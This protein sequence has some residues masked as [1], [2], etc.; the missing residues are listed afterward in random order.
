M[1][2]EQVKARIEPEWDNIVCISPP[3]LV[4]FVLNT[5]LPFLQQFTNDSQADLQVEKRDR[6]QK[7]VWEVDTLGN[8]ALHLAI[9]HSKPAT[10]EYLIQLG[11]SLRES[12][13]ENLKVAREEV[14]QAKAKFDKF[15]SDGSESLDF[16]EFSKFVQ[17]LYL[18]PWRKAQDEALG[19]CASEE[20][21]RAKAS[22]V[23]E[24]HF[25]LSQRL[26]CSSFGAEKGLEAIAAPC[27]QASRPFYEFDK[28]K[29]E[30]WWFGAWWKEAL[31]REV[32]NEALTPLETATMSMDASR[33][34]VNGT[35]EAERYEMFKCVLAHST[36]VLWRFGCQ[37]CT[38]VKLSQIDTVR[39]N[40]FKDK[41]GCFVGNPDMDQRSVLQLVL[42]YDLERL[43]LDSVVATLMGL[44]WVSFGRSWY[45]FQFSTSF[46]ELLMIWIYAANNAPEFEPN[47]DGATKLEY[48]IML[49]ALNGLLFSIFDMM[50]LV[51]MRSRRE[52][53][54]SKCEKRT[55]EKLAKIWKEQNGDPDFM[56]PDNYRRATAVRH[57]SRVRLVSARLRT[58]SVVT[59]N[60]RLVSVPGRFLIILWFILTKI[61]GDS[62]KGGLVCLALGTLLVHC[63]ISK[64]TCY[65]FGTSRISTLIRK[66]M[67]KDI[68]AFAATVVIFILGFGATLFILGV[69][70]LDITDAWL[71]LF[72]VTWHCTA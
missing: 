18:V 12:T 36:T 53:L 48:T 16:N 46:I 33:S 42:V 68:P 62:S 45:F 4:V 47:Q 55:D 10:F 25:L 63:A 24:A 1:M 38:Q 69:E 2:V 15:D 51:N 8:T 60:A 72:R 70:F 17:E 23:A 41:D 7:L 39:T 34:D 21:V 64:F 28:A 52:E 13:A 44:K 54:V 30:D 65:F 29:F 20:T 32:N 50:D 26:N 59:G 27:C 3:N 71:T 66:I 11:G 58:L 35:T 31:I 37:V 14:L 56:E 9:I 49:F 19:A 67:Q 57:H 43:A 5:T 22:W 6:L 61:F 40:D